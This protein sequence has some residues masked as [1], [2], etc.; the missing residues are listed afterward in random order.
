MYRLG[1]GGRLDRLT[2][3]GRFRLAAPLEDGGIRSDPG[4][5]RRG[6]SRP[7][8]FGGASSR[9]PL[10]R[11]AP[12]ARRSPGL[13]PRTWTVV[14][15]SL[16]N[17]RWSLVQIAEGNPRCSSPTGRSST[18]RASAILR[19]RSISSPTTATW[20]TSGR[21]GAEKRRLARWDEARNGVKEIS[22]P[23]EG[24][25]LVTT[26]EADGD[27]L[28]VRNLPDSPLESSPGGSGGQAF[29]APPEA[30]SP[31]GGIGLIPAW[32]SLRPRYWLP[33]GYAR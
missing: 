11:A 16:R 8:E 22:A 24:E 4:D 5:K 32:S 13:P 23:V 27:V 28:R 26:I 21:G 3:C 18:R 7:A 17:E 19:M 1:P 14:V 12:G 33:N 10:Y 2:E 29:G 25:L 15:T 6:G 20:T 9:R 30:A 31:P